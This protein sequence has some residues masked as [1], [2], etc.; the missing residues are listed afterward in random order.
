MRVD[1]YWCH[2][3]IISH[4]NYSNT[5][6][7]ALETEEDASDSGGS[8]QYTTTTATGWGR[9]AQIAA[10][11]LRRN[12]HVDVGLGMGSREG[13]STSRSDRRIGV[14]VEFSFGNRRKDGISRPR[15]VRDPD[16]EPESRFEDE[17]SSSS[18][19][20]DTVRIPGEGREDEDAQVRSKHLE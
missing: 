13:R 14:E 6:A 5:P 19:E 2:S 11:S 20:D 7:T 4:G 1:N 17:K 3:A 12:V 16:S 8:I 10:K 9:L 18:P 15:F